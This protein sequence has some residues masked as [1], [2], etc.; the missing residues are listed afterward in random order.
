MSICVVGDPHFKKTNQKETDILVEDCIKLVKYKKPEFTVILGDVYD[1]G[2]YIHHTCIK[3]VNNFILRLRDLC[4]VYILVG[5]HDRPNNRVYLTDDHP[6]ELFSYLSN[7]TIV[8]RC[9][10]F[11]WRNKKICMMPYVPNGMFHQACND[12]NINITD[13]DLFF[14]HQE[15]K[16]CSTNL[17]TKS[18]CDE[19]LSYYPFCV[20]GHIHKKQTIGNNL[21]YPGT[22]YQVK[23]DED[24]D[25]GIYIMN[26]NFEFEQFETRIPPKINLK[27][28]YNEIDILLSLDENSQYKITIE[29][30]REE[31]KQI[32]QRKEYKEK[33]SNLT[34]QYKDTTKVKKAKSEVL[35]NTPFEERLKILLQN[36]RKRELFE[37]ATRFSVRL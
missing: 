30:P 2:E 3:R 24:T 20:A 16:H 14:C 11:E 27:I 1:E 4:H 26:E 22:P 31:I 19:W 12:C 29:G 32:L 21:I 23:F 28:N 7:V 5:N 36:D 34:I 6:F 15:F 35:L 10:T 33:L 37:E 25:K 13:Y 8:Y 17:I 18:D 9:H